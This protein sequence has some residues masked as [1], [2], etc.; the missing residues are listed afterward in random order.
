M[1]MALTLGLKLVEGGSLVEELVF[2]NSVTLSVDVVDFIGLN[3]MTGVNKDIG[4]LGAGLPSTVNGMSV[5]GIQSTHDSTFGICISTVDASEGDPFMFGRITVGGVKLLGTLFNLGEPAV[6]SNVLFSAVGM[7]YKIL[8]IG[9]SIP[10][11]FEW[12]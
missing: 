8:A 2:N 3:N 9:S 12:N 10:V 11:K 7:P 5:V 4:P 6:N 1:Q